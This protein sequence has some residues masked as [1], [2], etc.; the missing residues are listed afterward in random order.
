MFF[1]SFCLCFLFVLPILE[2]LNSDIKMVYQ[3]CRL[4]E[5]K[6]FFFGFCC[7]LF[8]FFLGSSN[9]LVNSVIHQNLYRQTLLSASFFFTYVCSFF[10]L[11][12]FF[13]FYFFAVVN[14]PFIE[15][16]DRFWRYSGSFFFFSWVIIVWHLLLDNFTHLLWT[17]NVY[18]MLLIE[19][20]YLVFWGIV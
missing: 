3:K 5:N 12:F 20:N 8:F 16:N 4:L 11:L 15:N 13:I 18:V 1:L 17:N 10:F 19:K 9:W 6:S 7:L 2:I 14:L